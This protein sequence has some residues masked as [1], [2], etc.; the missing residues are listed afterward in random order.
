MTTV[1]VPAGLGFYYSA[2]GRERFLAIY[3]RMVQFGPPP[4]ATFDVPTGLG[5]VRVYRHGPAQGVPLVLLPGAMATAASFAANIWSGCPMAVGWRG[6][7]PC[8]LLSGSRR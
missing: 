4:A 7:K 3:D 6:T 8:V 5:T 1:K 2:A